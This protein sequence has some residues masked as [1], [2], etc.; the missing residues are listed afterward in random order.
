MA[1][2]HQWNALTDEVGNDVNVEFV[3]LASVKKG[4]D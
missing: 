3:D 4:S 1:W 2:C